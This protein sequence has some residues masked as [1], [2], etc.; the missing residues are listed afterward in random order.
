MPSER[1]YPLEPHLKLR[2]SSAMRSC[3]RLKVRLRSSALGPLAN[4]LLVGLIFMRWFLT[5]SVHVIENQGQQNDNNLVI[6]FK[7]Y[8]Q[9]TGG[10]TLQSHA[11]LLHSP[12]RT[13][14]RTPARAGLR[15]A[16]RPRRPRALCA[17]R[18]GGLS[19]ARRSRPPQIVF[20]YL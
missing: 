2:V 10:S 4:P 8:G 5:R 19:R 1:Q 11:A 6:P 18:S 15:R 13:A 9:E 16:A 3:S 17:L 12:L 14:D 20:S 7:R